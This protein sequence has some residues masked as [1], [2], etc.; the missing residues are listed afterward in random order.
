MPGVSGCGGAPSGAAV[1]LSAGTLAVDSG[2]MAV[3]VDSTGG[4]V[5][6]AVIGSSAGL[7]PSQPGNPDKSTTAVPIST[8]VA[9]AM[10]APVDCHQAPVLKYSGTSPARGARLAVGAMAAAGIVVAA[11]TAAEAQYVQVPRESVGGSVCLGCNRVHPL[12]GDGVHIGRF[13]QDHR[14]HVMTR[15]GFGQMHV[16]LQADPL[17]V[18]DLIGRHDVVQILGHRVGVETHA[19]ADHLRRLSRKRRT[20]SRVR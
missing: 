8:T 2:G 15:R 5:F 6:C 4:A 14:Q 16:G 17:E 11:A 12:P 9:S 18:A 7:P 3:D 10:T 20:V 13:T 19:G 1:G